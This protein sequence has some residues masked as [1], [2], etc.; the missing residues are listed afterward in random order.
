MTKETQLLSVKFCL[1]HCIVFPFR[2]F[3]EDDSSP[4]QV[5]WCIVKQISYWWNGL[6]IYKTLTHK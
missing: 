1:M 6:A 4:T 2:I 5:F 3:S